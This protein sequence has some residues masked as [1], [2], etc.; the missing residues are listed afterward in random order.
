MQD[1]LGG[2]SGIYARHD[3]LGRLLLVFTP[4]QTW[5]DYA[6]AAVTA[7]YAVGGA[8]LRR[9][10]YGPGDDEPVALRY[11]FGAARDLP[12]PRHGVMLAVRG[13]RHQR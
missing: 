7:E 13:P 3:P 11:R 5:F 10:F 9:Y 2:N 1:S 12:C 8:L 6:G 4:A